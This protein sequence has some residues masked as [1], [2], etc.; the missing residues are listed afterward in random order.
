MSTF[1]VPMESTDRDVPF[2]YV[3]DVHNLCFDRHF[4]N[5]WTPSVMA[6]SRLRWKG[7]RC[8]IIHISCAPP[9]EPISD[10]AKP[11]FCPAQGQKTM[12]L[13]SERH[14]ITFPSHFGGGYPPKS[15]KM[16]LFAPYKGH[17][18]PLRC[19]QTQYKPINVHM[20]TPIC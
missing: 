8:R 20:H 12:G 6:S 3:I 7:D 10:S 16:A 1:V 19:A 14:K 17:S 5:L 11:L 18:L 13:P 4:T 9:M 15:L 2:L